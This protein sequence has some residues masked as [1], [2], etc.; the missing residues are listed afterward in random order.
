MAA[1]PN[2]HWT[3]TDHIWLLSK[4]SS[5][6]HRIPG[7]G[8]WNI[9]TNNILAT[10]ISKTQFVQITI[11]FLLYYFYHNIG[12]QFFHAFIK[13][14]DGLVVMLQGLV[15]EHL[16]QDSSCKQ[17]S[18]HLSFKAVLPDFCF[19]GSFHFTWVYNLWCSSLYVTY[20]H[21][22]VIVLT[23]P[24]CASYYFFIPQLNSWKC[25][26]NFGVSPVRVYAGACS[27]VWLLLQSNRGLASLISG[28]NISHSL[29]ALLRFFLAPSITDVEII[30]TLITMTCLDLVYQLMTWA[31]GAFQHIQPD[32][33]SRWCH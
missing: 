27:G 5:L 9:H 6:S 30:T 1:S 17:T 11:T 8:S 26:R 25:A 21:P 19:W 23:Y 22:L 4:G 14:N 12:Q 31:A 15:F 33:H 32:F 28:L 18:I 29:E 16:I 20:Q 2:V 13:Y 7:I 24:A 10:L 3:P